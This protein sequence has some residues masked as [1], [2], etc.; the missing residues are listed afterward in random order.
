MPFSISS[1]KGRVFEDGWEKSSEHAKYY[2]S[3][4]TRNSPTFLIDNSC[5]CCC[6]CCFSPQ[7]KFRKQ[8]GKTETAE[9]YFLAGRS[10]M[11]WAVSHFC[12]AFNSRAGQSHIPREGIARETR[13]TSLRVLIHYNGKENIRGWRAYNTRSRA[14]IITFRIL[15]AMPCW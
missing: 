12:S 4:Y 14:T 13:C 5:C 10:M 2:S 11:W 15:S 3:E 1:L 8:R 7:S 9:T 6:C